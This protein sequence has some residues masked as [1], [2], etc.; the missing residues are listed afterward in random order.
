M[1]DS[2]V[3]KVISLH[4]S[5]ELS[6]AYSV[7][8]VTAENVK[9]V[10]SGYPGSKILLSRLP[11]A[12]RTATSP[13]WSNSEF[14]SSKLTFELEECNIEVSTLR[15][16][17]NCSRSI[18]PIELEEHCESERTLLLENKPKQAISTSLAHIQELLVV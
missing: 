7:V 14:R 16:S 3:S 10:S 4:A 8:V 2:L 1:F 18:S 13:F 12:D 17:R 11:S 9:F 15:V 6:I 5:E